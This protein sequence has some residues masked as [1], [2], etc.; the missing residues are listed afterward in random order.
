M[1]RTAAD[2]R[3]TM[4]QGKSGILNVF[5]PETRPI[6]KPSLREVIF[7]DNNQNE[8]AK[9]TTYS[10]DEP[11]LLR[12]PEHDTF[13]ADEM[14]AWKYVDAWDQLNFG[15]RIGDNPQGI[16]TTTPRPS[17]LIRDLLKSKNT[18]VT[19]GTT[20]EN[21]V[22]LAPAW[23][24]EILKK[25]EGTTIGRQE[26]NAEVLDEM[27]GALWKR[28]LLNECRISKIP[29][30]VKR[31]IAV[32]PATTDNE[33][34]DA[35]GIIV[36]G[37]DVNGFGYILDDLTLYGTP[38]EWA[39]VAVEAYHKY[40]AEKMVAETNQG[41]LMVESTIRTVDTNK[42]IV[43]E[44]IHAK[45]GKQLRAQPIVS[46][47][48]QKKVFHVG[49][50]IDLEDEYCNWVPGVSSDSPNRLDAAVYA[51]TDLMDNYTHLPDLDMHVH[52]RESPWRV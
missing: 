12:G 25:Y 43:Y 50:F 34:S 45:V 6:Y 10:A 37:V 36:A 40:G 5:P 30:L 18:V 17:R 4:V 28:A 26:L 51:L 41:G 27:P 19:R 11:D 13:W 14:A 8:I 48:E 46:F 2:V 15:L 7:I 21:R 24:S 39:T 20:Y 9:A 38:N 16:I 33:D 3:K 47:Y 42:E 49:I 22:N 23:F 1:G 44:S 31:V 32:D 52:A 29:D 35:T